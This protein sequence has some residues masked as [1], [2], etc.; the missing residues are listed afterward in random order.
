[1]SI[2][3]NWSY[4]LSFLH[5]KTLQRVMKGQTHP[6]NPLLSICFAW[7]VY[8]RS[9]P[10][11]PRTKTKKQ[12]DL[13]ISIIIF[14]IFGFEINHVLFIPPFDFSFSIW[15]ACVSF[16]FSYEFFLYYSSISCIWDFLWLSR[17]QIEFWFCKIMLCSFRIWFI[18][19][20]LIS[21]SFWYWS[22]YFKFWCLRLFLLFFIF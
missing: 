2:Y 8:N 1:M 18:L 4:F 13:H 15:S 20:F 17:L 22:V 9:F 10:F 14:Y 6:K 5:N 3:Q 19:F 11:I 21:L 16:L 7:I 12:V